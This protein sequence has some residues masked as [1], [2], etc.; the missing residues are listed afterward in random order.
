[1]VQ[2]LLHRVLVFFVGIISSGGKRWKEHR[3]FAL[4]KLRSFGFGKRSFESRIVEELEIFLDSITSHNGNPIDL[5]DYI[6]MS[7]SNN[8]MSIVVGRRY[9]YD[10][11]RF[12][13]YVEMQNKNFS[14]M[15]M[16]GP[17]TFLPILA[18]LPGDP[19]ETKKLN[20][21]VLEN[22]EFHKEE[23]DQH[24]KDFDEDNINCF[25]DAFIK[26]KNNREHDTSSTFTGMYWQF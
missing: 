13:Y 11:P 26:E 12:K 3:T 4:N 5:T 2:T 18:K 16:A 8:I 19:F 7:I 10:D 15:E 14:S 23:I 22:R 17:L 24:K 21:L 1:M 9:D 25:I 6:S 20:K